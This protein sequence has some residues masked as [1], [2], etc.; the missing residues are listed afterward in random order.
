MINRTSVRWN[1]S[2]QQLVLVKQNLTKETLPQGLK[3]NNLAAFTARLKPRPFKT[4]LS[5]HDFRDCDVL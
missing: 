5:K 1:G 3:P 2:Y 4:R